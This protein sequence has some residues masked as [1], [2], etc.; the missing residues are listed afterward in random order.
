MSDPETR[1]KLTLHYDGSAFHGWQLQPGQPT[2]QGALEAAAEQLAGS[3]RPVVG[4]GRT[5]TGVHA[6]GQVAAVTMPAR[7]EAAALAK[8]LNALVPDSLWIECAEPVPA[9]FNPRFEATS[10]SYEYRVGIAARAASPFHRRACWPLGVPLDL[11]AAARTSHALF[12]VHDFRAF[13]KSGQ[14]QR[15]HICHVMRARWRPWEDLG[16]VF[17]ITANRFLHRMVRYLVG[18]MVD[19]ARHRRAEE[20]M[21]LLL[22]GETDLTTS[23]PAPP[24]GLC[25]T[26]VDYSDAGATPARAAP[27][28]RRALR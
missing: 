21:A 15:G 27:E 12:G 3:R 10:R 20:E 9:D 7:W 4:A 8:S 17:E 24:Q 26:R 5:D 13:A 14:P 1:F 25:L 11:D 19:I 18:T 6:R 23:P 2:V 22:S 28:R 16:A